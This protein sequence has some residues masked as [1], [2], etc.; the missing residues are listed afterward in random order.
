MQIVAVRE[1]VWI[2][3]KVLK[4]TTNAVQPLFPMMMMA[5]GHELIAMP[6]NHA[7]FCWSC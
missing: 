1:C 7:R 3:E 2:V 6:P 4:N 5:S